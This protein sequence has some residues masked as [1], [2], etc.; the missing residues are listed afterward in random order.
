MKVKVLVAQSCPALCDP[1]DCS[2]PG[3]SLHG[4]SRQEYWSGQPFTSP[5]DLPNPGIEPRSPTLWA[6]SLLSEPP[7]K[8]KS[9]V[10][11]VQ[12][13]YNSGKILN[14][15]QQ[16]YQMK[17]TNTNQIIYFTT[18]VKICLII[19]LTRIM[20][21]LYREERAG[22]GKERCKRYNYGEIA[23]LCL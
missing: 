16:T 7:G 10:C 15:N 22:R 1:M 23:S 13:M 20:L 12:Y 6:D 4:I 2:L 8:P 5:G 21:V 3:S 14:H 18:V 19:L 17:I 9:T 11:I